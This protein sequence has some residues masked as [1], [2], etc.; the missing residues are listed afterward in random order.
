MERVT[1]PSEVVS[2]VINEDYVRLVLDVEE[3][4]EAAAMFVP[5]AIPVAV[6]LDATGREIARK[7]GFVE[8]ESY[9]NWLEKHVVR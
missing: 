2:N 1:Y 7:V 4:R 5:D 9:A 6:V 3:D 8:P